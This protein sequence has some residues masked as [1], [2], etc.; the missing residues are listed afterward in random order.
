MTHRESF[1][2][3]TVH[4]EKRLGTSLLLV[5]VLMA[6]SGFRRVTDP[7]ASFLKGHCPNRDAHARTSFFLLFLL[8]FV[9]LF[10]A[11]SACI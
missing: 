11:L 9:F 5:G 7:K 10:F 1:P 2:L 6:R 4:T 8:F 3:I